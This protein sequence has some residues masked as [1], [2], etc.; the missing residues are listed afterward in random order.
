VTIFLVISV[1]FILV[2]FWPERGL[3][4]HWKR[5]R[6]NKE[7]ILIEDALKHIHESESR[8]I[9]CT[10]N[11]L[12]GF[13]FIKREKALD[14]L[15]RLGELR[16]VNFSENRYSLT[17]TGQ[18][19]A[20]RILRVHRLLEL[21]FADQTGLSKKQWHLEAEKQEHYLPET[22]VEEIDKLLGKPAYDPHGDPIPTPEGVIPPDRGLPFNK[23]HSG[24]LVE[25]THIEDEPQSMYELIVDNNLDLGSQVKIIS[26]NNNIKIESAGTNIEIPIAAAS[27]ITARKITESEY[28]Q[29]PFDT[30]NSLNIGE[31]G[32]VIQLSNSLI[33]QQRRRLMDLGVV[34]GSVITPELKS[35]TGNPTAYNIRGASI[36]LRTE[37]S[38]QIY[39]KKNLKEYDAKS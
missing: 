37:Q 27:Q 13:L 6:T 11:S 21:Y 32:E 16:M 31:E 30:L 20:R 25:I 8:N 39:I 33:G 36:A 10:I 12:A 18:S 24:E 35:V 7:K 9:P 14:I 34:P 19:H 2:I 4:F 38:K 15:N 1:I 26:I 23:F 22:D 17:D 5:Y 28:F 29:G 3:W